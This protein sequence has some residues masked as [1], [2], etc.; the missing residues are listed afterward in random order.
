MNVTELYFMTYDFHFNVCPV[1]TCMNQGGEPTGT[2]CNQKERRKTVS[3][4]GPDEANMCNVRATK[5]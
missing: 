2:E 3:E 5:T 4:T 1:V